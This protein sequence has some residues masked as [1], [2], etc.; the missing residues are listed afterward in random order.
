MAL[1]K[2]GC[3]HPTEWNLRLV[4]HSK[5]YTYCIGCIVEKIGLDNLEVYDNPFVKLEKVKSAKKK[6]KV[7]KKK[8]EVEKLYEDGKTPDKKSLKE[9]Q[10]VDN[11]IDE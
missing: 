3:G 4:M 10:D 9:A 5:K 7:V 11:V 1:F 8:T 2:E 6:A